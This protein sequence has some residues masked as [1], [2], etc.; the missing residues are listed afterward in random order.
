[1]AS[2]RRAIYCVDTGS[3]AAGSFAWARV[4]HPDEDE[5]GGIAGDDIHLLTDAIAADV[6]QELVVALG[7][8]HPL[9]LPIAA[10]PERLTSARAGEGSR[11]W[12]A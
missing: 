6:E 9:T 12:S 1:M 7:F 5:T 3:I 11:A 8:E 10:A 2:P 4:V